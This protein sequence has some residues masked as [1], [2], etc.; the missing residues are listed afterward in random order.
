MSTGPKAVPRPGASRRGGYRPNGGRKALYVIGAD[1]RRRIIRAM[2]AAER[3]HGKTVG[4]L[5]A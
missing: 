2:R 4:E 1:E 3:A 5:M